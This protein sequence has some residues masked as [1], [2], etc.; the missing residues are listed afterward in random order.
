MTGERPFRTVG[1]VIAPAAQQGQ[2]AQTIRVGTTNWLGL[3]S[4]IGSDADF[5]QYSKQ[6]A[7]VY[8][9]QAALSAGDVDEEFSTVKPEGTFASTSF[10]LAYVTPH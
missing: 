2:G 5:V 4:P 10:E 6:V 3:I 1:K 9:T 8:E 7:K